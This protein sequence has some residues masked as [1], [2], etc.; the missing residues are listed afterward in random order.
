MGSASSLP[1][2][3]ME[4]FWRLGIEGRVVRVPRRDA[5]GNGGRRR[6]VVVDLLVRA[7]PRVQEKEDGTP[8]TVRKAW[9]TVRAEANRY[10]VALDTMHQAMASAARDI[11]KWWSSG[12]RRRIAT[13][14]RRRDPEAALLEYRR[15]RRHLGDGQDAPGVPLDILALASTS[16]AEA[17]WRRMPGGELLSRELVAEAIRLA[18]LRAASCDTERLLLIVAARHGLTPEQMDLL[19]TDVETGVQ[20]AEAATRGPEAR[21]SRQRM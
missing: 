6:E 19:K 10:G 3:A 8:E 15:A 21:K 17:W 12:E 9:D 20:M 18:F 7:E 13:L 2:E 4:T 14:R 16:I 5:R 11:G 1:R